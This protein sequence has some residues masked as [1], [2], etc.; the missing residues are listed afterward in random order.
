LP[1][2][3]LEYALAASFKQT[4]E[5]NARIDD[6]HLKEKGSHISASLEI[7]NFSALNS[8]ISKIK[9]RHNIPY[10]NLSRSVD[11]VD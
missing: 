4:H 10:R 5:S 2:E 7:A 1:L 6:T 3:E 8:C 9:K 11:S